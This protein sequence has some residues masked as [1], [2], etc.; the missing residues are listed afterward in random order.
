MKTKNILIALFMFYAIGLSA[1]SLSY[2]YTYDQAGN[3][4]RRSIVRLSD[5]SKHSN[6]DKAPSSLTDYLSDG[7]QMKIF[8]NPTN[9]VICF[10]MEQTEFHL[11]QYR[12]Y[13][14][15][16]VQIMDGVCESN[17]FELNLSGQP[18]GV[19]LIEFQNKTKTYRSKI[20]KE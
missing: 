20:I 6:T 14:I 1:Q 5:G 12:V 13:D 18:N 17:R 4:I 19:Y 11:G 16:G 7:N 2:E 8:P 15:K 9:D 10:E 3:R